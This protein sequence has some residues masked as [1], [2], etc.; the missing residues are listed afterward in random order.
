MGG[1]LYIGV[2]QAK[3]IMDEITKHKNRVYDWE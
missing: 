2:K 1:Y 3:Q